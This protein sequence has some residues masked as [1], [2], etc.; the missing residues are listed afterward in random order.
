MRT[1]IGY[2]A[3]VPSVIWFFRRLPL[4]PIDG[5]H[6]PLITAVLKFVVWTHVLGRILDQIFTKLDMMGR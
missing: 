6:G 3:L 5:C 1:I 2:S 4:R